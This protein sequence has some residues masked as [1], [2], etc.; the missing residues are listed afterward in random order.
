MNAVDTN[1]LVRFYV[2]D[3]TD[4][5]A[6]RQRPIARRIMEK[7]TAVHVPLTVIQELVWALSGHYDFDPDECAGVIEHLAGL[8]NVHLDRKTEVLEAVRLYRAKLDFADAMHVS[9][10]GHCERF[11]TFDDKRFARRAAKLGAPTPVEVPRI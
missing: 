10:S 9:L 3:P 8:P 5:E 7:S 6:A 4:P 11:L 2:D 1:I